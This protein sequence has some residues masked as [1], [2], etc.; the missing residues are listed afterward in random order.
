MLS[1]KKT[2]LF[3]IDKI[4]AKIKLK[5]SQSVG[6]FGCGNFGFFV[7][8]L[9]KIVGK[10]GK[11]Y[12]IDILKEVLKEIEDQATSN[13]LPQVKAIWSDL[14]VL[15]ATKIETA[16][17]DAATLINILGLVKNRANVLKELVRLMK[18]GGRALIIDW[19]NED[20]PI[21]PDL[22]NRISPKEV[23]E[24]CS[25]LGLKI[26]EEFE[27]GPYHYGFSVSKL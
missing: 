1:T 27:A 16:S 12:A 7:F 18:I 19:K 8:P 6:E 26:E 25:R 11:V 4:L 17:L 15:K 23:K 21:G 9:A 14:E 3:D 22:K 20:I 13:N 10:H 5:E 2:I 24:L